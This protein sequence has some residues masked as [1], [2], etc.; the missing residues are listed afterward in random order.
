MTTLASMTVRLG[1]DTD[2]LRAGA[3]RAVGVLKNVGKAVGAVGVG[4]PAVAATAAAVG[5]MAAAFAS[6][7]IAAMAFQIAAGPQMQ[8]VSDASA[9]AEKAEAAHEKATLKTAQAQK[10]AATGGDAYKTAL[11]EAASA[12]KAAKDADAAYEQQMAGLPPATRATAKALAGLKSDQQKWSDSLSSSTMPVFTK[13]LQL[14]R[15]LLPML[16]PFVKAAAAAFSGFLDD[17]AEGV[18]SAGFKEW[19]NDMSSAAGPSLTSFL[20]IVKNLAVGFGALLGAFTPTSAG[21]T[22]GLVD[23]TAAF[24]DWATG[25]KGSDGFAQFLDL[26]HNGAGTLGVLA[27]A[28]LNLLVAASPLIGTT[29]LIA[30]ALAKIINNTPAPVLTALA[31]IIAT[32]T[33]AMKAYAL[34][35]RITAAA[36]AFLGSATGRAIV[37]WLRM[38]AVGL[39]AYARIAA[40]AVASAAATAAAWVGSALVSIGTWVLAVVRAA[41][42]AVAQFALMAARA[43]VWAATMA[44][45]WLIAM[46]PIGWIIIA[47]AALVVLIIAYWD[48]IKAATIAAWNAVWGF[49]KQAAGFIWNL[50]LNWTIYGLIIKH[51]DSIRAGTI[52]AWNAVVSFVRGIPGKLISFFLNWTLPGLIIKHWSAIKSGTI[53]KA[54]EMIDWVRGIPSRITGALGDLGSLLRNAGVRLIQGFI[55]GI[56]SKIGSVKD[57]LGGLTSSLTSW[58]GP[59]AVDARILTPAGKS[60]IAGFQSGITLQT[61]ALRDQLQGLTG[62]LPGMSGASA[63]AGVRRAAGTGSQAARVVI[64]VTGADEA[65][66]TVIRKIVRVDGRGDVQLAF[67]S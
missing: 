6:A 22:G 38:M 11:T 54:T 42:V 49:I 40:G 33:L 1:I 58:K 51:W 35:T 16:T 64:D 12:S 28:A 65:W 18:K 8:A 56:S 19:A 29:V 57:T 44:A 55:D 26:A 66:K 62:D 23:M 61:P 45:S 5:G 7:G 9:S 34:Y 39:M 13:G 31:T 17:V 67:G 43:I 25:L 59:P 27:K 14:L 41:V 32:V 24:A 21:V 30:N 53:S 15:S 4:I 3:D 20:N 52:T 37:A 36:T 63:P 46:G 47:V 10:L 2:Q 60:L 50:F 48:E